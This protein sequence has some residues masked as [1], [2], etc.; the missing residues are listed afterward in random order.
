VARA[1]FYDIDTHSIVN[2]HISLIYPLILSGLPHL[3]FLN[4]RICIWRWCCK[5]CYIISTS[6][7]PFRRRSRHTLE[8]EIWAA[9]NP[10]NP[11]LLF[12]FSYWAHLIMIPLNGQGAIMYYTLDACTGGGLVYLIF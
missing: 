9:G 2:F 1:G 12:I 7:A 8:P 11:C 4:V 6:L 10:G 3:I 5:I